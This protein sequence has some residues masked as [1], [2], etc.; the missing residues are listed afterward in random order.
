MCCC[1]IGIS[2]ILIH[3]LK[4]KCPWTILQRTC[5]LVHT[6]YTLT[7][8]YQFY[9]SI[10]H[11]FVFQDSCI[12]GHFMRVEA[13][14]CLCANVVFMSRRGILE[15]GLSEQAPLLSLTQ[16]FVRV[17]YPKTCGNDHQLSRCPLYETVL[18]CCLLRTF[19]LKGIAV[20]R[21]RQPDMC[22]VHRKEIYHE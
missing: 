12:P 22:H 1:F 6:L 19:N 15:Q 9:P 10:C 7:W 11:T 4:T 21:D 20:N 13:A 8:K 14:S 5:N 3:V 17:I 18:F 16:R 2:F